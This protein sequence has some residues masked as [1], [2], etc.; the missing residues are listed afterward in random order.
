MGIDSTSHQTSTL[1]S[2]LITG[3]EPGAATTTAPVSDVGYR[4]KDC[5]SCGLPFVGH[6]KRRFCS[7]ECKAAKR[8]AAGRARL[9]ARTC[10]DC[11]TP[12][13]AGAG[14]RW[15]RCIPC[16]A[17]HRKAESTVL[18]NPRRCATLDCSNTTSK[19]ASNRSR[20]Y[21]DACR[22]PAAKVQR[23]RDKQGLN[24]CAWE[25]CLKPARH[26]G[27]CGVHYARNWRGTDM[28]VEPRMHSGG[29]CAVETCFGE[30][31]VLGFCKPHY[32]RMLRGTDMAP[33]LRADRPDRPI[34]ATRPKEGKYTEIKTNSGW[35]LEHIV[36]M[37]Q[38]LGHSLRPGQQIH[39]RNTIGFD[40]RIKNL[41]LKE[42]AHGT[43]GDLFEMRADAEDFLKRTEADAWLL[44]AFAAHA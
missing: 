40:N 6:F 23:S 26:A 44:S 25:T 38:F 13:P 31:R 32:S 2:D 3:T 33:P 20:R 43:G 27:F 7:D 42:G 18:W 21:C 28:N 16:N 4:A 24:K 35:R 29:K 8:N 22:T 1:E 11:G 19:G 34:G 5:P 36:V 41:Q 10:A 15:L 14:T 12:A 17:R 37:E 30:A 39:H 9:A